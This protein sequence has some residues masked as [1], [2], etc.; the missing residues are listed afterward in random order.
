M[1][2]IQMQAEGGLMTGSTPEQ[3]GLPADYR[4]RYASPEAVLTDDALTAAQ[5][6]AV[7]EQWERDARELAVAEE[8][9]MAGGERAMLDRVIA[10][11]HRLGAATDDSDGARDKQG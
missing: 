11:L 3:S 8:E 4:T 9:G 5:K 1:A 6:A 7:L 10:A 2:R